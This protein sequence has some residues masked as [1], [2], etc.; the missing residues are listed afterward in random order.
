[1]LTATATPQPTATPT[2]SGLEQPWA[3]A[4]RPW[5]LYTQDSGAGDPREAT[6]EKGKRYFNAITETLAR[7]LVDL[8]SAEK[9]DQFPY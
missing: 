6:A 7:F 3:K 8:A 4:P 9:T 5:H 1:M 2:I